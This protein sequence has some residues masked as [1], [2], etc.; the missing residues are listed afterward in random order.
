VG[1]PCTCD[2][3]PPAGEAWTQAYCRLCWLY[4]T[5][6]E[7]RTHWDQ[8]GTA[9]RTPIRCPFTG[10]DAKDDKGEQK[11][12]DCPSCNGRVRLK[13]FGCLHPAREPEE[14]TN[15]DCKKCPYRPT[16]RASSCHAV[17]IKN[18]LSPGDVLVMSA[19][20]HS[21][22]RIYPGRFITAVETG[23]PSVWDFNPDVVSVEQ[24]KEQ[25]AEYLN[26]PK[27]DKGHDELYPAINQCNQHAAHFMEA[28]CQ[29]IGKAL[30]VHIPLVTNRPHVYI[31]NREKTWI[32][33]C[34]DTFQYKGKFWLVNA[35]RKTDF[36]TKFWGTENYQ[37]VIDALRGKIVFVQVG[38]TE[39]HHPPLRNVLDLR[40]KTDVRQLI[41]LAYHAE[42]AIGG[43][44]FLQHLMAAL[45]KPYVCILGGR[46]PVQWN[47]YPFQQTLHTVGMMA[48]CRHGGCWKSRTVA[49]NDGGEQDKS[50]CENPILGGDPLPRCMAAIA[51]SEVVNAVLRYQA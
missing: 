27:D 47:Q 51:P 43:V 26:W 13:L 40:G 23:I 2:R 18:G 10:P 24:A 38:S 48:C 50:L 8:N 16:A 35:G 29:S 7:Y 6:A 19:A 36:T 46:E 11:T 22:H 21:L 17:I 1:R 37:A 41:R 39:H 5:S 44:T 15:D 20:I 32:N 3:L 33:Q 12:R 42:G 30:G 25:K 14:V 49:L 9:A 28:Y 4:T 31:S 45:E 34:E